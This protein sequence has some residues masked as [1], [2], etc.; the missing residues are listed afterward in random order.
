MTKEQSQEYYKHKSAITARDVLAGKGLDGS[1]FQ[2]PIAI[3]FNFK[4]IADLAWWQSH[5]SRF[6]A[7]R[8]N[9]PKRDDSPMHWGYV[10]SSYPI[11]VWNIE[12]EGVPIVLVGPLQCGPWVSVALEELRVFGLEYIIGVGAEELFRNV[13]T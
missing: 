9:H 13:L 2:F 11:S 12:T 1:V 4:G 5:S 3:A 6:G 10:L 8:I 7:K